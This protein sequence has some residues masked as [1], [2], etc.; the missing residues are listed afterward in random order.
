MAWNSRWIGND[1]AVSWALDGNWDGG[2]PIPTET[3]DIDYGNSLITTGMDQSAVNTLTIRTGLQFGGCIGAAASPLKTGTAT[4]FEIKSPKASTI[5]LW[6]S[7]CTELKILSANTGT[8]AVHLVD[9][10][11]TTIYILAGHLF[12]GPGTVPTTVDKIFCYG[13]YAYISPTV[14]LDEVYCYGGH[15]KGLCQIDEQLYVGRAGVY[16]HAADAD[17][18]ITC[19]V[20]VM[21]GGRL[22]LNSEGAAVTKII[23]WPGGVVDGTQVSYQN[24]ITNMD[25]HQ[26]ATVTL[27]AGTVHTNDP[28]GFGAI[29]YQG[30]GTVT[31]TLPI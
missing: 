19:T 17:P 8:Y 12:I 11:V 6:P 21:P 25:I 7:T 16:E 27:N 22:L 15:I 4:T 2:V 20:N 5:A 24:T 31:R 14:H 23:A 1:S 9:G 26:G 29:N 18:N 10:T 3:A 30:P 13:G 28:V